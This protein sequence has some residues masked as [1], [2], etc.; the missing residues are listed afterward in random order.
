MSERENMQRHLGESE[1]I[2]R[3]GETCA[4]SKSGR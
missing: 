2:M 3:R 4:D 1:K